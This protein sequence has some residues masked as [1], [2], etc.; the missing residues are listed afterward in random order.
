ML[1]GRQI[2]G[3]ISTKR[4]YKAQYEFISAAV[5]LEFLLDVFFAMCFFP[6]F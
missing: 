4:Y 3:D 5:S 2:V 6:L 1:V